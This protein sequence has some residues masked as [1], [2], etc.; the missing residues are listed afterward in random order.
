MV[1]P[2]LTNEHVAVNNGYNKIHKRGTEEISSKNPSQQLCKLRQKRFYCICHKITFFGSPGLVVLV[3]D[4][5][6]KGRGFESRRRILDG[7]LDIFHL[8]LF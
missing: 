4:S 1:N 6:L 5:C 7:H 8:D 3:N 2:V